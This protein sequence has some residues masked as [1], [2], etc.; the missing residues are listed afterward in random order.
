V[1]ALGLSACPKN[2]RDLTASTQL[3]DQVSIFGIKGG[4]EI[5]NKDIENIFSEMI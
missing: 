4:G 5:E 2:A 3:I 1:L